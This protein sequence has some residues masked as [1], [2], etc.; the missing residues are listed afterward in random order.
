MKKIYRISIVCVVV[1]LGITFSAFAQP[2]SAV[3]KR[4]NAQ[5]VPMAK[6]IV[7]NDIGLKASNEIVSSKN[8]LDDP[9]L[10]A[11]RYDM[12]TNN[13]S[14][15]RVHLY[16]DGT[17]G[18]TWTMSLD[19]TW[20]QRGTGY[21]YFN[22]TAWGAQPSVKV[23]NEKTGWPSYAPLGS[24]G[25]IIV[26]HTMTAGLKVCTRAT[27]GTGAW[28]QTVLPG[29]PS[30]VDISWP[31]VVTSGPNHSIVHVIALTYSAY[32]NLDLAL[33]YY[34]SMDGGQN[35]DI[36][37]RILDGMT[38][39]EYLGFKADNYAWA[40]PKGDTICFTVG[41]SWT[42]QFIM[43][44]TDNGTTWTK[45][46]IW[47][48]P[49]NLWAGGDTTGT[50]WCPDGGSSVALD[51]NGK[52]HVVFGLMRANGDDGGNKYWIPK[53]DG[54]VYWNEDMPQLTTLDWDT[55]VAHHNL[56][57]WV[58]DTNI[59][60]APEDELAHYYNSMTG[61]PNITVDN[62]G[63]IFVVWSGV[64][65]FKDPMN[66][67]LRHLYVRTGYDMGS[68]WNDSIWDL[69]EGFLYSFQECAFPSMSQT[70]SDKL[71]ILFS[72][73][74]LAGAYLWS[75]SN[76]GYNGQNSPTDNDMTFLTPLKHDVGTSIQQGADAK[77]SLYVSQNFP[78]PSEGQTTIH[79]YLNRT[80]QLRL[81]L[82][83]IVGQTVL[84]LDRG[85]QP[86]G[87]Q[88]LVVN[89]SDLQSGVYF[90]TVSAGKESITKKLI[91]K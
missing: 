19:D 27:K 50:F 37:N 91:V 48:C 49:Y 77:P 3:S 40:E 42:D 1:L 79:V 76:P 30:A 33:L 4:V 52:A 53:T 86:A 17:I 83:N 25:E 34:R 28:T 73:D 29:P 9:I 35:W 60:Y 59:F 16:P 85:E 2:N 78:N 62:T 69:N 41:D 22:G 26:S 82:K 47:P 20:A 56:I 88:Q 90:Y 87:D 43:K 18:A 58:K 81:V 57:G 13:S 12:Q 72:A 89:T 54:V 51:K 65:S 44:S 36:T 55:L 74:A 61:F 11:T 7:K 84:S 45:T 38:S 66:Y 75:V 71:Q 8:L 15:N 67:Y 6:P 31:R 64:S 14:A 21:N 80:S 46:V 24:N 70:S 63:D 10:G 23:E 32:E 68:A 5:K 39:S